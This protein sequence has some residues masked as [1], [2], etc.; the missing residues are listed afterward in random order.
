DA[1]RP[2]VPS[3]WARAR[4]SEWSDEENVQPGSRKDDITR[5]A[6]DHSLV[7]K[8]TAFVAVERDQ[9]ARQPPEPLIP[10]QQRLPLPE[11]VSRLALAEL[12]RHDIP[13]GDPML[14]IA[15]PAD[16]R[17]VTA[18]CSFGLVKER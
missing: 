9:V 11:G 12:S 4:I 17:P 16:A 7:S 1:N 14:D 8:Y 18:T 6:L 13:P 15:A 2:A 10:V 3:L 5:I